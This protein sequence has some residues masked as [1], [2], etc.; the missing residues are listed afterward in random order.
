MPGAAAGRLA[1][2]EIR[3][4]DRPRP[5]SLPESRERRPGAA[6]HT[7]KTGPRRAAENKGT[8]SKTVRFRITISATTGAGTASSAGETVVADMLRM[9]RKLPRH[10]GAETDA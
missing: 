3:K 5:R 1:E 10:D 9:S 8:V 2:I 7:Q 4:M 6:V